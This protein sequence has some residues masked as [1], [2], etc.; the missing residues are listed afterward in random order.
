M[1]QCILASGIGRS[2]KDVITILS[3]TMIFLFFLD[4]L[5]WLNSTRT[6][7]IQM[8]LED[9]IY[10][11]TGSIATDLTYCVGL[12]L[13]GPD[14]MESGLRRSFNNVHL[15]RFDLSFCI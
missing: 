4:F 14:L 13:G 5:D 1:L 7:R 15:F 8:A 3:T 12:E 10:S 2:E 11:F 6:F 9:L